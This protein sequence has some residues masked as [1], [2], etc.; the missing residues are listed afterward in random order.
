MKIPLLT[1]I[2]FALLPLAISAQV[3][4]STK[5]D[6]LTGNIPR[7]YHGVSAGYANNQFYYDYHSAP[8]V[9][10]F[11]DLK[12]DGRAWLFFQFNVNAFRDYYSNDYYSVITGVSGLWETKSRYFDLEIPIRFALQVGKKDARFRF[13][14]TAGVGLYIPVYYYS[15]NTINGNRNGVDKG[16][17]DDIALFTGL[18]TGF[19]AKWVYSHRHHV[20]IGFNYSIMGL[21][22]NRNHAFYSNFYLKFGWNKYKK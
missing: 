1:L 18:N 14:P 13:F 3:P 11:L 15:K 12:L 7:I 2:L 4:D 19:E 6:T 9:G 17:P 21:A 16:Y 5:K 8:S 22:Y 10:Y 20:G